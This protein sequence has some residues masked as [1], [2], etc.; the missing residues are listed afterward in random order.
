[1]RN[2][3]AAY[4]GSIVYHEITHVLSNR[5]VGGGSTACLNGSQSGGM[6]EGWSDFLAASFSTALPPEC[7]GADPGSDLSIVAVPTSR[8]V[9]AGTATTTTYTINTAVVSGVA[10]SIA[11]TVAGLPAG[12]T[13]SFSPL[14]AGDVGRR[15]PAKVLTRH[16]LPASVVDVAVMRRRLCGHV[17]AGCVG[18]GPNRRGMLQL[19]VP[20]LG[21]PPYALTARQLAVAAL[22]VRGLSNPEVAHVLAISINTVKKHVRD[23]FER[24]EV[25]SRAELA[26]RLVASGVV[27]L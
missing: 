10:Q 27:D 21:P 2:R 17:V 13:G 20:H 8:V 3:D 16:M 18:L 19:R 5:L 11:L 22:V 15:M 7:G 24:C 12:V 23:L 1:L 25:D 14:E 6:G 26:A 4:D 9:T